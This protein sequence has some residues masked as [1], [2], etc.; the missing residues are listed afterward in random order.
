MGRC[1][2]LTTWS[3]DLCGGW[4]A[5]RGERK[6]E[7]GVGWGGKDVQAINH[8]CIYRV[9]LGVPAQSLWAIRGTCMLIKASGDLTSANK[10]RFK[11]DCRTEGG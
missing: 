2:E 1:I 3:D 11:G 6:R 4:G 8:C 9:D 5:G 10:G 7:G